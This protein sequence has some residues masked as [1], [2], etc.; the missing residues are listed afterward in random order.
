MNTFK[1]LPGVNAFRRTS[2]ISDAAMFNAIDGVKSGP[3][4]VVRHGI[5]GTQNVLK[6][7]EAKGEISQTVAPDEVRNLQVTD[8]AKLAQNAN[9]MIVEFTLSLLDL[10]DS[11]HSIAAS[12][13]DDPEL[14]INYRNSIDNFI[15]RT[16]ESDGLREVANRFARNV[17]NGRWLWRNRLIAESIT[18][19]VTSRE[20]NGVVAKAEAL[21]IPLD[22][23]DSYSKQ[24]LDLGALLIKGLTGENRDTFKVIATITPRG[25]GAIEVFPSQNYLE[26]KTKG[27]SRSLYVHHAPD[28]VLDSTEHATKIIGYAAIRDQKIGNALRT[29]DTWYPSEEGRPKPIAVEPMGANLDLQ[30]FFRLKKNSSFELLKSLNE[31]DPSSADGMFVTACLIRGG[32]Y[33]VGD[34][35]AA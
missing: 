10:C 35:D 16:K 21:G 14:I 25:Q 33:S 19:E 27:F 22:N 20:V 31:I 23:F 8:S 32:V 24:E 15:A 18:V 26:N 17:L 5:M 30:R 2:V 28:V 3:V 6:S 7:G 12:R 9:G 29:I 13:K 34:K 4:F 11:L 1:K